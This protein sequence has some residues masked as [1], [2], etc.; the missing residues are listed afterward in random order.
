MFRGMDTGNLRVRIIAL[1]DAAAVNAIADEV[2]RLI[3]AGEVSAGDRE[4]LLSACDQ[5]LMSGAEPVI[6]T[7]VTHIQHMLRT[8][9]SDEL[10][11]ERDARLAQ[12]A[13][14]AINAPD[15]DMMVAGERQLREMGDRAIP[16]LI[17]VARQKTGRWV[18]LLDI[19]QAIGTEKAIAALR[20]LA[21]SD[22]GAAGMAADKLRQLG[23]DE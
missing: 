12:N 10:T 7:A 19:V 21:A 3:Q 2:E 9:L 6:H 11:Q 17:A 13:I 22:S 5:R 4:L 23:A 15:R 1:N 20:E 8:Q 18:Y 14:E 16:T